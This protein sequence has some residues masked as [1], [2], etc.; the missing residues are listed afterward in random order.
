MSDSQNSALVPFSN[1]NS[2][3]QQ[4]QK[5]SLAEMEKLAIHFK[6]SALFGIDAKAQAQCIIKML[7][8]NELGI[9]P[10]A[11]V[12]DIHITSNGKLILGTHLVAAL[13]KKSGKYKYK[14]VLSDDTQCKIDFYEYNELIGSSS[15]TLAQAE[16]A[17]LMTKDTYKQY[18]EEMLYSRALMKGARRYCADILCGSAYLPDEVEN[19]IVTVEDN[20]IDAQIEQ[21]TQQEIEQKNNIINQINKL[22]TILIEVNGQTFFGDEVILSSLTLEQLKQTTDDLVAFLKEILIAKIK[23]ES[24]TIQVDNKNIIELYQLYKA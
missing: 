21:P 22:N 4:N 11:S 13:I 12:K 16:K 3:L 15:F 2:Q 9:G 8:G 7:A 20:Y 1:S 23:K 5:L 18:T 24:P 17:K 19:G 14:V 10:W 6:A